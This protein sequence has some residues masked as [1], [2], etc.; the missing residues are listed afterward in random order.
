MRLRNL[1]RT[2]FHLWTDLSFLAQQLDTAVVL[3]E[4]RIEVSAHRGVESMVLE[5][6]RR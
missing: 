3:H 6:G 1:N 4:Y 2:T 5:G